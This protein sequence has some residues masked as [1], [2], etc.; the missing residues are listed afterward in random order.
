MDS[1]I[2]PTRASTRRT[3][4]T[5]AATFF[6]MS[7]F[8]L[9]TRAVASMVWW[10]RLRISLAM[11]PKPLP[12]APAWAASM[13]AFRASMLVEAAMSRMAWAMDP[14][15]LVRVSTVTTKPSSSAMAADSSPTRRSTSPSRASRRAMCAAASSA[16]S[17]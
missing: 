15:P 14:I 12:A 13:V 6:S 3:A 11:T 8:W 5:M 7:S 16:T 17:A 10:D 2:R 4:S 9:S 1:F